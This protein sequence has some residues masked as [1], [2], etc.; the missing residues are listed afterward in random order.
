MGLQLTNKGLQDRKDWEAKGIRLPQYDR[1]AM[2]ARTIEEPIWLHFGGGNIF[3]GYIAGLQEELLNKAEAERGIIAVESFD[4]ESIDRIYKPFEALTLYVRLHAD[5]ESDL[6][7]IGAVA[8]G[9]KSSPDFAEDHARLLRYFAAPS[10]QMVSF[11]ITEK[12]YALRRMDGS[13]LPVVEADM[14]AGPAGAQHVMGIVAAGLHSRFQAGAKPLAV[15][16]MD[17]CSQNG[18]KLR[19][20]V[21]E[22]ARQW[23]QRTLVAPGFLAWLEDETQVA[24]PW[25]MIDKITPRPALEIQQRLEALGI[26]DMK[27]METAKHS[28]IAPFVNAEKAQYLVIED[29]FPNGRPALEKAGVYMTDR[30]TVEQTEGMKVQTCLNPL[31]TA[32]AVFGCLLGYTSIA[33]EMQDEALVGLIRQLGYVEGM[34]VVID[35]GILSPKDFIDEVL[36]E[37]LPNPFIPDAP[38]RIAMDTSQKLPIRFGE[39]LKSYLAKPELEVSSLRAIPSVF[40]GW[41]RYLIG[42]DDQGQE[43][44]CSPD[45]L[46]SDLQERLAG[47]RDSFGQ[48][49]QPEQL[50][51]LIRPILKNQQIFGLD[52]VEAGLEEAVTQRLCAFLSGPGAV[53]QYLDRE[54]RG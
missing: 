46:L 51:E 33:A 50:R 25:S 23:E 19:E 43:M 16:S 6:Q 13:Y 18:R 27:A 22:I 45:P 31:H 10:L 2:Q 20:S 7:V 41:L 38:Q 15:V 3:R 34:P 4:G 28:F 12:G 9:I 35:P 39:T 11:T 49:P 54:F 26:E 52:L 44:A 40:A 32:L 48:E 17:N 21:L 47:L 42:L 8:D 5:G 29:R 53:R 24:F 1:P 14:Q 37:R 30:H 36:E